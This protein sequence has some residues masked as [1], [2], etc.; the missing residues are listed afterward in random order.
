MPSVPL[1][2]APLAECG[3]ETGQGR[4]RAHAHCS[5]KGNRFAAHRREARLPQ[6]LRKPG[7]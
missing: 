2:D 3:A 4:D 1:L 6:V 7:D 5:M